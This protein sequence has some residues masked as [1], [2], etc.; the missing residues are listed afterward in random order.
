M[1]HLKKE[2]KVSLTV[3][4]QKK[5]QKIELD[6]NTLKK[7]LDYSH[8]EIYVTNAEGVVIYVNKAS[9]RH[10]GVKAEEIIGKS[11]KE[12]SEK[13]YWTPRLSPIAIKEK[14]CLTIEQRTCTGKT[15][16]TTAT[17]VYD[18][19]GNLEMIIENSRD[20]T[21]SE[22]IRHQLEIS[23]KLLE[24]YKLEVEELRKKEVQ[25]ANLVHQ[26]KKMADLL[27]LA[28]RV[29]AIDSTVLLLGESG[30]GKGVLAKFIHNN[31]AYKNGPFI[32]INCA[33]IPAEL[34]ESELFGYS[35]GTFT[36]GIEKGKIGLIELANGGTLFLDEIAEIPINL[37]AK[38]LQVL[39]ER[40][41]Y[42]VGGR[43]LKRVNCRIIAATNRNLK[44]MIAK[45]EFRED[46]Y[47]RLNTFE[48]EI[49]PLRERAEDIPLLVDHFLN[50][51]NQKYGTTKQISQK[52]ME[53]L[54]GYYWP[55]NVRELENTIER[56]TVT[57]QEQL[58]DEH[59]LPT[60]FHQ[61]IATDS[62]V[63]F[64][65]KELSLKEAL[66]EVEKNLVIK[67][68]K[69]LGSSYKVAKA[70]KTS[71]SKASRLIRKYCKKN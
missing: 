62:L 48:I 28:K 34:M 27:E 35:R 33:A 70:L 40:Q 58:I 68:Y 49:P 60:P 56:L 32:A 16:L 10:Y 64:P 23:K 29:A 41:Y 3:K 69:E 66:T 7:I 25:D 4:K 17:P 61:Q 71:Q 63:I 20:I 22:G 36:G 2:G 1:S 30:T 52:C 53:K 50:K 42:Q 45:G 11:S 44:E 31:S 12:I 19:N 57:V 24:R 39:Q 51:F 65:K 38:L 9:E 47:Y 55:G 21:E 15:L 43:E 5:K 8:D 14:N 26:S 46:L 54:T 37:Q 13:K 18:E 6:Y 59:H 67:L